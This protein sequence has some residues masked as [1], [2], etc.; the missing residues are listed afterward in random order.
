M[1]CCCCWAVSSSHCCAAGSS[2]LG[3]PVCRLFWR[4]Q[5]R[6]GLG[7]AW[8][9]QTSSSCSLRL[10]SASSPED[11]TIRG[12]APLSLAS[13]RRRGA[14][15]RAVAGEF[16]FCF[17]PFRFVLVCCCF[18]FCFHSSVGLAVVWFVST[19]EGDAQ[20]WGRKSVASLGAQF[21]RSCR[22]RV[23]ECEFHDEPSSTRRVPQRELHCFQHTVAD[24]PPL[25]CE[26]APRFGRQMR[27]WRSVFRV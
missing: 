19:R 6:V 21:V 12:A 26:L 16:P 23:A 10:A 27:N 15:S 11:S 8:A 5:R 4:N 22:T 24:S 25:S 14:R 7:E 1:D 20:E 2:S 18:C 17:V 3:A 9:T 13:A